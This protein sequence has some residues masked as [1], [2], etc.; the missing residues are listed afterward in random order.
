MKSS[1]GRI[2]KLQDEEL[3]RERK[4]PEKEDDLLCSQIHMDIWTVPACSRMTHTCSF[5]QMYTHIGGC[6]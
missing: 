1:L 3:W 2:L 4:T 5:C 6:K